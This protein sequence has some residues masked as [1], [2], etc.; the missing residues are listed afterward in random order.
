MV[1]QVRDRVRLAV[2]RARTRR[3]ARASPPYSPYSIYKYIYIKIYHRDV[4]RFLG[5][6]YTFLF[7]VKYVGTN[8]CRYILL[9]STQLATL[10]INKKREIAKPHAPEPVSRLRGCLGPS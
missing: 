5:V 7:T 1:H 6:I 2:A 3:A 8:R 10:T 9:K 4:I